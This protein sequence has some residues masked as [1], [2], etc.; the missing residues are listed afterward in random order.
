MR[1]TDWDGRGGPDGWGPGGWGHDGWGWGMPGWIFPLAWLIILAIIITVVV[2]LRRRAEH[3]AGLQS[4]EAVLAERFAR[5][6]IDEE[7]YRQRRAVLHEK[8]S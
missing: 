2:L 8:K 1:W 4:G 5:G 6:E 3:R 7:E